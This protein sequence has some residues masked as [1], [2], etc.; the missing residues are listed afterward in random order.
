VDS[1]FLL[2]LVL[3]SSIIWIISNVEIAD[4]P[5]RP[6]LKP[7][8]ILIQKRPTN[9]KSKVR[10]AVPSRLAKRKSRLVQCGV[11]KP[12]VP[13]YKRNRYLYMR[14]QELV[15]SVA[16]GKQAIAVHMEAMR[17]GVCTD[18]H[19]VDAIIA[20]VVRDRKTLKKLQYDQPF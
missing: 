1:G 9:V 11:G 18:K 20:G 7:D 16:M 5:K 14:T 8:D 4:I 3:V 2:G 12:C 13:L 15:E 6:R 19:A 17:R 10:K